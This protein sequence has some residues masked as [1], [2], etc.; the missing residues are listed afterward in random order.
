MLH[1]CAVRVR[2]WG[3]QQEE[4]GRRLGVTLRTYARWERGES[5]GYLTRLGEVAAALE[6]TESDLLGG[7]D[8]STAQPTIDALSDK[9]DLVI[10]E[11]R[12]LRQDFEE[13]PR[14]RR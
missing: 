6:T 8:I 13:K 4:V 10:T 2:T 7:E 1:G 9:I 12:Q 14:R 3:H 11:L 5:F